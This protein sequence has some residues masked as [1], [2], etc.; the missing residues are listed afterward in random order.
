MAT[1]ATL[2]LSAGLLVLGACRS[3]PEPASN[4]TFAYLLDRYDD[5]GDG[6]I[7]P[8][9]YT[10]NEGQFERWD[11]DGDERL[12]AADW[13]DEDPTVMP[14]IMKLAKARLV[15]RQFQVDETHA[16]LGREEL[17]AAFSDYDA[18]GD[19]AISEQEFAARADERAVELPGDGSMMMQSYTGW[20]E[21]W[22]GLLRVLDAD[23]SESLALAELEAVFPADADEVR[24]DRDRCDDGRPGDRFERADYERG[25]PVGAPVPELELTRLEGEGTVTLGAFERERPLA[26]IFGSYT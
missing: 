6:A 24:F 12:T 9:E 4:P 13:P 19:G 20:G 11:T 21:P 1:R 8:G 17:A 10:R 23:A 7:A 3:A 18:D 16:A 15:G 22:G 2:A 26:L 5:N 14:A 25:L